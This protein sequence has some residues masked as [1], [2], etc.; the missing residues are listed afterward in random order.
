MDWRPVSRSVDHHFRGCTSLCYVS[1]DFSQPI[2]YGIVLLVFGRMS[3]GPGT[4][5]LGLGQLSLGLS[6]GLEI[7]NLGHGG[8]SSQQVLLEY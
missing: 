3:L 7:Q 5:S 1:D 4:Q 8:L 2:S 6:L